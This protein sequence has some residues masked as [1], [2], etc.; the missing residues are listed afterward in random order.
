MI[1]ASRR[2]YPLTINFVELHSFDSAT[3]RAVASSDEA[4]AGAK[5]FR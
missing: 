1:L 5:S 3:L 4:R 2:V